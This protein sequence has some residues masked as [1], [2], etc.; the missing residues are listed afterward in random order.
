[1]KSDVEKTTQ[2]ATQLGGL[3]IIPEMLWNAEG[4]KWVYSKNLCFPKQKKWFNYE[5]KYMHLNTLFKQ[6]PKEHVKC[7]ICSSTTKENCF[8]YRIF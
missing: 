4:F 2:S 8:Y 6:C 3:Q 1:M 5:V 7:L